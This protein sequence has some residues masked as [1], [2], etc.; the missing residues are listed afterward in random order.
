MPMSVGIY[1]STLLYSV[2]YDEHCLTKPA[3]RLAWCASSRL[4]K[5]CHWSDRRL[6]GF[7][8]SHLTQLSSN[9]PEV[10]VCIYACCKRPDQPQL[11][12]A[13]SVNLG[14]EKERASRVF[15]K[16]NVSWVRFWKTCFMSCTLNAR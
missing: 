12:A 3:H 11:E 13:S 10:Q 15:L 5:N 9:R 1:P 8:R 7:G 16:E 4:L 14:Q 2:R 6:H